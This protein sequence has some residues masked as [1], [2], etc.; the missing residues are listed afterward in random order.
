MTPDT[1][2]HVPRHSR[3]KYTY[4]TKSVVFGLVSVLV[5]LSVGCGG[6]DPTGPEDDEAE[7][8]TSGVWEGR[9]T[10]GPAGNDLS[11][12]VSADAFSDIDIEVPVFSFPVT[13]SCQSSW[14]TS[15]PI[16]TDGSFSVNLTD[17]G[18]STALVLA[19]T[20]GTSTTMTGTVG[21]TCDGQLV[22]LGMTVE[23]SWVRS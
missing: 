7:L 19:G 8:F 13:G 20:F 15:V 11:F 12:R 21:G 18:A 1:R 16:A 3:R 14:T 5:P 9:V 17:S 10:G 2:R 4:W 23:A 6:D 22:L